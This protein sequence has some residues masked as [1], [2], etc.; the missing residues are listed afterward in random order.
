MEPASSPPRA[1]TLRAVLL[2][3]LVTIFVNVG[4]PVSEALAFSNFSWSYLPEGG[5]IPF[6]LL[7]GFNLLL[8]RWL[9]R[10]ALTRGELLTVF[11]MGLVSNSTSLFLMFFHLSAIVSPLYFASPGNRWSELLLPNLP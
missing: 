3:L 2:G 10:R 7:V 4:S 6:L 9:P 1:I 8:R 11:V 5:V